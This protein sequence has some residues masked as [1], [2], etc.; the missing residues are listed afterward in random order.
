MLDLIVV[1]TTHDNVHLYRING[2]RVWAVSHRLGSDVQVQHFCWRPDG[3]S[4]SC[5]DV[6]VGVSS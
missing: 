4:T 6:V 5:L 3:E 2:Q 1:A